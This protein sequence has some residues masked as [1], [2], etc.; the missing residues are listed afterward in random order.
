MCPLNT[1]TLLTNRKT[2]TRKHNILHCVGYFQSKNTVINAI[3][4]IP[5]SVFTIAYIQ[6]TRTVKLHI[7]NKHE[8]SCMFR[9]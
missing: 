4:F 2:V 5:C 1:I 6:H 7:I 8:P 3:L 9:G